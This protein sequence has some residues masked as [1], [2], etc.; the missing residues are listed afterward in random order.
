MLFK[1]IA[2]LRLFCILTLYTCSLLSVDLSSATVAEKNSIGKN[3]I[4][5]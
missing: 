2:W 4:K 1:S 5:S 3:K